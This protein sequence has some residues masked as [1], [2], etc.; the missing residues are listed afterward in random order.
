MVVVNDFQVRVLIWRVCGF[1][2]NASQPIG[3]R[4]GGER[5]QI[6]WPALS[7]GSL[8]PNLYIFQHEEVESED[9][10]VLGR[11]EEESFNTMFY[12]LNVPWTSN[13]AELQRTL[14]FSAER[15]SD[16]FLNGGLNYIDIN[17]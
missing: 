17:Q 15:E 2:A 7:R 8:D 10:G 14:A 5:R 1:R 6:F 11:G 4:D 9:Q 16:T 3:S 12:D 13:L